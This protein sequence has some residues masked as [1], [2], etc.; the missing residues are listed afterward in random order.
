[1]GVTLAIPN[2][3]GGFLIITDLSRR[4]V[5]GKNQGLAGYKDAVKWYNTRKESVQGLAHEL[6][7]TFTPDYVVLLL[8]KDREQ[9]MANEEKRAAD[10]NRRPLASVRRTLFD[11][12][13]NN[14]AYE[15]VVID[16]K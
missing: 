6:Q 14:G 8:P 3:K 1:M 7:L 10:A 13:L 4:P 11:F 9:K 2:P 12:R 5:V 16:Q 15:P